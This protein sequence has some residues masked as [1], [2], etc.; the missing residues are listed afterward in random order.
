VQSGGLEEGKKKLEVEHGGKKGRG[1][2]RGAG[3]EDEGAK[4]SMG[5]SGGE[6]LGG[7]RKQKEIR[8]NVTKKITASTGVRGKRTA[9]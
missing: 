3:G 7:Y 9:L 6:K 2:G 8:E 4:S 5:P 1:G